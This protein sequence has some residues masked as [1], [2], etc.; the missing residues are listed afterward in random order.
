MVLHNPN[1]WHWVTKDVLDWTKS[2]LDSD[3]SSISAEEDGVTA[4][5]NSVLSC[6]GDAEV[7][8]RKGK[9]ITIFDVSLSLEY[10]GGYPAATQLLTKGLTNI[11]TGKNKDGE[12]AEGTIKIP[13][14]M[15]D[16][17]PE[18]LQVRL[19]ILH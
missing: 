17:E 11:V 18:E 7:S 6:E 19:Q 1:N 12:T 13:E 4:K 8:Q 16:T 3:L 5:I 9:V 15:H 14:V 2:Y 10:S